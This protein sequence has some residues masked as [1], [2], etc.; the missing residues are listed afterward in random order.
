MAQKNNSWRLA[1]WFLTLQL[2]KVKRWEL[3]SNTRIIT[4]LAL[5]IALDQYLHSCSYAWQFS[6]DSIFLL[7][8]NLLMHLKP[9][10][11]RSSLFWYPTFVG[12]FI[13]S[14]QEFCYP[15][16]IRITTRWT[17]HL[18]S[19][20]VIFYHNMR[21]SIIDNLRNGSLSFRQ[22]L[23]KWPLPQQV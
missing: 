9:P 18:G 6:N 15:N 16:G 17:N 2:N 20:G 8:V 13:E 23:L 12:S 5:E 11:S 22:S 14:E 21:Y 7:I 10:I 19:T 3:N 4:Y 1:I